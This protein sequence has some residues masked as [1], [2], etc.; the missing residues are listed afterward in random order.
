MAPGNRADRMGDPAIAIVSPTTGHVKTTSF[1]SLPANIYRNNFI[2]VT[3]QAEH[4]DEAQIQLDGDQLDCTWTDIFNTITDDIIGHGCTAAVTAGSHVIAHTAANRVLSVL[5]YGW[6]RRPQL[7]YAY[8]TGFQLTTPDGPPD[9]ILLYML[10]VMCNTC[11]YFL[12]CS[13]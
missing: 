4:F 5:A 13:S 12:L 10:C 2:S 6:N 9:G 8:L 11:S 3:V 7:G 1:V